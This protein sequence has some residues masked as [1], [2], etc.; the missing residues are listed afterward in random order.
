LIFESNDQYHQA[1]LKQTWQEFDLIL[2]HNYEGF[3]KY[4]FTLMHL[5]MGGLQTFV[6]HETAVTPPNHHLFLILL[7]KR[8]NHN[9]Q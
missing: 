8:R 7:H 3:L 5:L 6:H 4:N 9:N 1:H 2:E